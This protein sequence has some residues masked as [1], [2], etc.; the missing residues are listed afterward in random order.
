MPMKLTLKPNERLI[1]NGASIRNGDRRTTLMIE[2]NAKLLRESDIIT[3]SE[4]DTPTKRVYLTLMMIHLA[5][6][7]AAAI[8]LL[9]RQLSEILAI[10]PSAAA[11][12]L[13]IR[14]AIDG[15]R[16]YPALKAGQGLIQHEAEVRA[17]QAA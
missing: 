3:E 13:A 7:A 8:D 17:R 5:D 6:Q 4:A 14:D 1:I 9:Y 16:F 10:L 12:V 2:T 11:H 15:G